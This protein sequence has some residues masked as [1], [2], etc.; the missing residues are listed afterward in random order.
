MKKLITI[1]SLL[2]SMSVFADE[3][4]IFEKKT[5]DFILDAH[6]DIYALIGNKEDNFKGQFSFSVDLIKLGK[7]HLYHGFT[8]TMFWAIFLPGVPISTMDF[9]PEFFWNLPLNEHNYIDLGLFEH[10][11]NASIG[12]KHI[13]M[14]GSYLR[15][16]NKWHFGDIYFT[17]V[18]KYYFIF[19]TLETNLNIVNYN[20][21][22]WRFG[23]GIINVL[24]E[25]IDN[26]EIYYEANSGGNLNFWTHWIGI[27]FRLRMKWYSPYIFVQFRTG[28]M[29]NLIQYDQYGQSLRV[30]LLFR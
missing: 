23:I 14:D 4:S 27:K 29:E 26:K 7:T 16:V 20:S 13:S 8:Q 24:D 10:K 1:I 5:S 2:L 17:N 9:N 12:G 28:Y 22:K 15:Y 6:K 21:F 18:F 25:Y 11:S 30:G 3:V 19:N